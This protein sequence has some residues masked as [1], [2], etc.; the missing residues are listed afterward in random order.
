MR[1]V[2]QRVKRAAVRVEGNTVGA[3]DRGILL[4][5]AFRREDGESDLAWMADK[6]VSLRIFEDRDGKI[7]RSVT[8]ADGEILVVSQFTL[9]A[10]ARRGRRPSLD[11][12]A[13]APLARALFDRFVALLRS[14][15][16]EVR[17]GRFQETMDVESVNDGPVTILVD[18]PGSR[19]TVDPPS[20]GPCGEARS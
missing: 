11:R 13:P 18:S 5:A 20:S 12:A 19:R 7:N 17:V 14:R 10:D 16:P 6:V 3:I 4:Y 2:V 1:V 8:E 15:G 9:Y